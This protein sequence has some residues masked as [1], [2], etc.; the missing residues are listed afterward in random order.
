MLASMFLQAHTTYTDTWSV[1]ITRPGVRSN[2]H[3]P[4][5]QGMHIVYCY[6]LIPVLREASYDTE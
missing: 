5:E 4:Q 3:K 6:L 2:I 1:A